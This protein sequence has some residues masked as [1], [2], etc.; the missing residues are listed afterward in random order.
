MAVSILDSGHLF[1]L[2]RRLGGKSSYLFYESLPVSKKDMLNANYITCIVLTLFG[3]FIIAL[4]NFQSSNIDFG[5]LRYSTAIAFI[6]VNFLSIPIAFSR[7]TEKKREGISY[8][9]YILIMMLV[10]PFAITIVFTLI[11]A[12]VFHHHISYNIFGI[13]YNYGLL[14]LSIVWMIL[15]Y[16]I[17]LKRIIQRENKGGPI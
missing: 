14:S 9:P 16:L 12:F 1:R 15:N 5:D 17:Q 7:N 4:Y 10:I 13:Y 6:F 8:A 3:G 2:H 11:N